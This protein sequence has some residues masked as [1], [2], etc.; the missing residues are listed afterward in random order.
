MLELLLSKSCNNC[1]AQAKQQSPVLITV[2]GSETPFW[3]ARLIQRSKKNP[4]TDLRWPPA[5]FL[6]ISRS[7]TQTKTSRSWKRG[8]YCKIA[9]FCYH[10]LWNQMP[11][12]TRDL[13]DKTDP[14]G[15]AAASSVQQKT[16]LPHALCA[17]APPLSCVAFPSSCAGEHHQL[18]AQRGMKHRRNRSM[19]K[20]RSRR[21]L[22]QERQQ[23]GKGEVKG[24]LPREV[25]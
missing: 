12:N 6:N 16:A 2:L 11:R 17:L 8:L 14:H 19:D 13:G 1:W 20:A 18:P 3:Q 9:S 7:E 10:L 22:Q 15:A 23:R 5:L 4:K 24:Q 21:V 25:S